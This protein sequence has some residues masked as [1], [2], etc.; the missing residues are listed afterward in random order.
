MFLVNGRLS[1]RS[2]KKWKYFSGFI[3]SMLKKFSKIMAQTKE[4]ANR[5]SHFSKTKVIYT[6]NIKYSTPALKVD[7]ELLD[8]LK[9]ITKKYVLVA[10]STH[11]GED[12]IIL[13]AYQEICKKIGQNYI[14]LIIIP[15]HPIRALKIYELAS[16][17]YKVCIRSK[18]SDSI[19]DVICVDSFGEMGT[20]F[21]IADFVFIGGS[22]VRVGGHNIFEPILF[23]KPV[24]YGPHMFNFREMKDLLEQ[25]NVGF[26]VMNASDIAELFC[27]YISN[28]KFHNKTLTHLTKLKQEDPMKNVIS[29]LHEFGELFSC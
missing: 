29:C 17:N 9:T 7:N 16:Q 25:S 19:N 11:E 6:G 27:K 26:Q 8:K 5:F 21:S 3:K 24:M 2:F 1:D 18:L 23:Q 13:D 10:A 28:E 22:L 4:D 15:R 14:S 20:F 12:H